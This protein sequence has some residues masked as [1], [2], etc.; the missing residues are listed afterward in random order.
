MTP[1]EVAAAGMRPGTAAQINQTNGQTRVAQAPASGGGQP[2]GRLSPQDNADLVK[3]RNEARTLSNTRNL[4]DQM[5]SLA[6]VIDS[7]GLMAM[8]GAGSVVGAVDPNTRRFMQLTDQMTPGMRQGLPGAASDRDV[9][10]FRSATPSID[11]P[12]EA[13]LAAIAAGRAMANNSNDYVAFME[14]WARSNG[15]LIGAQ[16]AWS[17][18]A[19]ANPLFTPGT[20]GM[21]QV[22]QNRVPWRRYFA[23]SGAAPAPRPQT[24]NP[25]SGAI[26]VQPR[27][28]GTTRRRYNPATGRIE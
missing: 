17:A 15:S 16:E 12:R 3:L 18:Y 25:S 24:A 26:T 5:E 4:Y 10:M 7:G 9:A 19:N 22:V 20:R 11:K 2:G 6:N 14:Q 8:P 23:R 13:N 28:G 21:P 27:S 1:E